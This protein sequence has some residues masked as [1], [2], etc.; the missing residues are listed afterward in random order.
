MKR[1]ELGAQIA[2]E[3]FDGEGN[4]L[5]ASQPQQIRLVAC[6][7]EAVRRALGALA[8]QLIAAT[9]PQTAASQELIGTP[10]CDDGSGRR[11]GSV[12][13]GGHTDGG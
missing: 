10:D 7:P 8:D 12:K 4:L 9:W 1:L 6:S 13:G 2:V 5:G 3:E 11:G